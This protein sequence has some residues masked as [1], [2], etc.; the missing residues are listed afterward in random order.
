MKRQTEIAISSRVYSY[1][2]VPARVAQ[3]KGE[4]GALA[5][6][7]LGNRLWNTLVAIERTR[8]A[9]YRA[10]MDD[11]EQQRIE[12]LKLQMGSLQEE[13]KCRRKAARKRAG[14]DVSNLQ[15]SLAAI[16]VEASA[17]IVQRKATVAARHDE[18]RAALTANAERSYRRIKRAR[19]AAASMGLFWGTYNDIVQ[20]ADAGK[21]HGGELHFRGFRGEGTLTAQIMGGAAAER[22][23]GGHTFFQI[24][25]PTP[26]QKWRYARIRI[27]SNADRSPVWVEIPIVYHRD[28]PADANIRSVSA[29]RRMDCGKPVWQLNVTV[30][31]PCAER[32]EGLAVAI[33]IGWRL[34]PEGVRVA[35]WQD[36]RGQE[37]QVLVPSADIELAGKVAGLRSTCDLHRD[38]F[39]PAMAAW[40]DGRDLSDEWRAQSSHL[41]QWKSS[42][43]LAALVRW[44][45]DHRLDGDEEI[46]AQAR[47]WRKQHLHLSN[48][49]RSLQAQITGKVREQYRL[50]A[51][52]TARQYGTVVMEEFDMREVLELP[53]AE[54]DEKAPRNHYRQIVS[55]GLFRS[56]LQQTCEREGVRFEK[57]PGALT[58]R[59]CHV[60]HFEGKWDALPSVMHRCGHCG[61]LWDQDQNAAANLLALWLRPAQETEGA[62]A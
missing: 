14:V 55:P 46:H 6:I 31:V 49:W 22:A 13:M 25:P 34:L 30:N 21:K 26:G 15:T 48:W 39:L 41:I 50:F 27:G 5:Q 61:T 45:S 11:P 60:C 56:I 32:R 8:L 58:T 36:E 57:I 29:T 40:L 28:I 24:D 1:G 3:V 53:K 10:I 7:K 51:A 12:E 42:D 62:S 16:R 4:D 43:R 23:Y 19:Q 33:D 54:S 44:W 20:R 17:L 2:T 18:R 52:A 35:Y 37:G 47:A 38:E 9:R 59:H